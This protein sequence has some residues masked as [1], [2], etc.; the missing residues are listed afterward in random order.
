MYL[1]WD[2]RVYGPASRREVL[3]GLR[4]SSFEEGALFWFEGQ[5]EWK[6]L[7]EFPREEEKPRTRRSVP[8]GAGDEVPQGY[9]SEVEDFARGRKPPRPPGSFSK[10]RY[11]WV[12]FVFML[13][14][15]ALTVGILLLVMLIPG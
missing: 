3:A 15:A 9:W 4:A 11:A 13:L 10:A 12:I 5:A 1:S 6:P 14:G 2:G 7:A 8:T